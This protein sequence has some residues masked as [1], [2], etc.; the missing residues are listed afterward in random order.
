MIKNMTY[1]NLM[2]VIRKIEKKGYTFDE[3]EPIARRIFAE[4]NPNGHSIEWMVEQVLTK[5]DYEDQN[6]V[7]TEEE[8]KAMDPIEL[9]CLMD[10]PERWPEPVPGEHGKCID[11]RQDPHGF[12][13]VHVFED[14]YEDRSWIG[15]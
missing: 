9:I 12:Y 14:G 3:A 2:I 1:R 5:E 15:D 8:L 4:Y 11:Y 13:D 10:Q 7:L 6:N